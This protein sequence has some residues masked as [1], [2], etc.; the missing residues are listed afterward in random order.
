MYAASPALKI[1]SV[2]SAI[3]QVICPETTYPRCSTSHRSVPAIG[4][5]DSDHFQPD[6]NVPRIADALPRFST[7]TFA[8][9]GFLVSS[10]VSNRFV[11]IFAIHKPPRLG[12][13]SRFLDLNCWEC[14]RG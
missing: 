5:T 11:I 4:L 7:S 1:N 9:G 10:G 13:T 12:K 6:S 3:L 14:A 8:F 2:P